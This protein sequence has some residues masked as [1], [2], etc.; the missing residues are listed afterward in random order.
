MNHFHF[1]TDFVNQLAGVEKKNYI[2]QIKIMK[3]LYVE[4]PQTTSVLCKRLK[5]SAPNMIVFLSEMVEKKMIEKKGLGESKGGR[6]PDLYG[7][8]SDCFY[9]MG[10]E[11][12]IFKTRVALFNA[13]NERLTE[14]EEYSIEL[15]NNEETLELII[16]TI[17]VFI[18]HSGINK[19]KI[20]GIGFSMP[21]LVD[22]VHGVN[23]TYLN[24]TN[25]SVA[26]LLE[27]RIGRPVF[28]E[29]DAKA[30]ALAEFRL[31]CAKD[32]KDVLALYLDWGIGLGMILDGHLYRGSTGFAGEFSHIPMVENGRLCRCGKLGC[33][34]TVASGITILEM[35]EKGVREHKTSIELDKNLNQNKTLCIQNVIKAAMN[36]DQ[37][38]IK[39][40][41]ETGKNLGKGISILIQL[42][43][44]E[45][46]VLSGKLSESG[47]LI[48]VPIQQSINAHSMKQISEKTKVVITQLG[49][50]I[51]MFGALAVII[52][53][54]FD[55]YLAS[56]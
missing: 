47:D 44:P 33:V 7:V 13:N 17:E 1:E 43:N 19:D 4:G 8:V 20:L 42:F 2:K 31:G 27:E 51:G 49:S 14:I 41:D 10:V 28:I 15:N 53:N 12:G 37:Y 39:I 40:L 24:S 29:N 26:G 30:I 45:L 25:K 21:G 50:D 18:K 52:E 32:K 48:T 22:S 11:M 55:K 5:I 36:G 9:V 35:A 3:L 16:E 23:Y 34:E 46:I 38:A 54:V 56:N 6:K